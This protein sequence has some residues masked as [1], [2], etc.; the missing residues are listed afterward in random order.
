MPL[1][2]L[3]I[4][5]L[6]GIVLAANNAVPETA[7]SP[8]VPESEGE[9]DTEAQTT[10]R[11]E[12]VEKTT[13]DIINELKE[14]AE[15]E[16]VREKIAFENDTDIFI[17]PLPVFL[18]RPTRVLFNVGAGEEVTLEKFVILVALAVVFF[19]VF[20]EV[21]EFSTMSDGIGLIV[22]FCLMILAAVFGQ[23][24]F[25][26][27]NFFSITSKFVLLGNMSKLK[28]FI[29]LIC[30]IVALVLLK[31]FTRKLKH[32]KNKEKAYQKG[33]EISKATRH[34]EKINKAIESKSGSRSSGPGR[35]GRSSSFSS[36]DSRGGGNHGRSN[37][38]GNRGRPSSSGR[39]GARRNNGGRPRSSSGS[40]RR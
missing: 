23:I 31:I 6:G 13:R 16:G 39:G 1:L 21:M 19:L 32:S 14:K 33:S 2:L 26:A 12:E 20:S 17:T 9:I 8:E 4:L 10:T 36:R 3:G 24:Q 30:I 34:T 22:A 29:V 37:S 11:N 27:N 25:I 7:V 18:E 35:R 38:F 5:L 40:F 15:E 28:I